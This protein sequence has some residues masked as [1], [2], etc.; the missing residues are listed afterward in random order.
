MKTSVILDD[1]PAGEVEQTSALVGEN[2]GTI[3][4]MAIRAGLPVV[5]SRFQAPRRE[6]YF[7]DDYPLPKDRLDLEK[8]M[9][10]I[11]QFPDR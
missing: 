7:S 1:D 4:R 5:A 3:L 10:K 6:G 11:H 2:Q 9:L 8:A